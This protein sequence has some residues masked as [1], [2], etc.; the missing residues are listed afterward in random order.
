MNIKFSI[1]AGNTLYI[2]YKRLKEVETLFHKAYGLTPAKSKSLQQNMLEHDGFSHCI[3][4]HIPEVAS[5]IGNNSY[6]WDDSAIYDHRTQMFGVGFLPP[7]SQGGENLTDIVEAVFK[8]GL[9]KSYPREPLT[10]LQEEFYE[11]LKSLP[12]KK[13]VFLPTWLV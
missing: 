4:H 11:F 10:P 12:I 7:P 9:T 1:V 5:W 8:C 13:V 2:S 6:L 3:A